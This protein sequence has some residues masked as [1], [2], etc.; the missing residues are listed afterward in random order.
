[1]LSHVVLNACRSQVKY[2]RLSCQKNH[3]S[4]DRSSSSSDLWIAVNIIIII[5]LIVI[6]NIILTF[7]FIIVQHMI[8]INIIPI[9]LLIFI[10]YYHDSRLVIVVIINKIIMFNAIS[11]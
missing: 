4:Y 5:T 2:A 10:T 6:T 3:H 9:R 11:R 8:N 1:M 7:M